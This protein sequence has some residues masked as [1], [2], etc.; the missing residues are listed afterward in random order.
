[1]TVSVS[2]KARVLKISDDQLVIELGAKLRR[3][4]EIHRVQI[5]EVDPASVGFGTVGAILLQMHSTKQ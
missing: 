4:K 3:L 1:M 5:P 2:E